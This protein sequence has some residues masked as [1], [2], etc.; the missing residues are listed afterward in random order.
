MKKHKFLIGKRTVTFKSKTTGGAMDLAI[1]WW[2][3][4]SPNQ[5]RPVLISEK[6]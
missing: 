2:K 6:V 3:K 4:Y 1:H 5:H